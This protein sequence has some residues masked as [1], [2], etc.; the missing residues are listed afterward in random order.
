MIHSWT[1]HELTVTENKLFAT[2]KAEETIDYLH[3]LRPEGQ[4]LADS[5]NQM[6]IYLLEDHESFAHVRFPAATWEVLSVA[7]NDHHDVILVFEQESGN[8]E[9]T[10]EQFWTEI[11]YLVE[12]IKGNKNY[13]DEM[14]KAVESAFN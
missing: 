13:G 4:M 2:T 1:I 8:V 3:T 11:G 10:L 7:R 6:F 14:V 5:D 9:M 12:N